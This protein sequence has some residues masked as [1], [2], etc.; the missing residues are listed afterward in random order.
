MIIE[1]ERLVVRN[2]SL[3]DTASLF[4]IFSDPEVMKHIERPYTYE[5]TEELMKQGYL[6]SQL[7][8]LYRLKTR[9]S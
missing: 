8:M 1:T 9:E 2:I 4:S 5:Q 3:G 7:Y 6:R